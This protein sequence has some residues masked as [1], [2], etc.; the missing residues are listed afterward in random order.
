MH[1]YSGYITSLKEDEVFVFGSNLDGFH[2]AG[3]AGYA[4]F[5]EFGNV[6]RNHDYARKPNGWKGKWN[7]KG[8]GQGPQVGTE[9]KSYAIPTVAKA[10]AKQSLTAKEI[11]VNVVEFFEFAKSRPHLTFLVAQR[12][13]TDGLNGYTAEEMAL[14]YVVAAV[15]EKAVGLLDN[16]YYE[17]TFARKFE[18]SLKKLLTLKRK[19]D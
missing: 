13:D 15:K 4:S 7:Q 5:G 18:E 2:G 19:H 17:E 16:V 12:G 1:T 3:A 6:W 11:I 8:K 14:I 9:G 10:G